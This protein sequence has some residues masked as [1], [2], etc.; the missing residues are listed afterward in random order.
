MKKCSVLILVLTMLLL[1]VACGGSSQ[2]TEPSST[3]QVTTNGTEGTTE[4]T[5]VATEALTEASTVAPTEAPTTPPAACNHSWK[6]AT[7]TE[8]K[9]CKTCGATNG[10]AVGHNWK[11]ATCTDP[12]KCKTCGKTEGNTLSHVEVIQPAAHATFSV[13]GLTEGVYC[14]L[15]GETLK[16]QT[17]I[18]ALGS[19]M[20]VGTDYYDKTG[21]TTYRYSYSFTLYDDDR[22]N[23]TT[24]KIGSD[25]SY[26]L[27]GEDGKINY[28]KNGVYE[29]IFDSS[30]EHMYG[31][32]V[33]G[34]FQFC[35]KDGKEWEDKETRPQGNTKV[36]IT[37]RAG[38][39]VYGYKDLSRN[40]HGEAMQ[41]LY[42]RL[43]AA[44][45]AFVD[46]EK[47][48]SSVK[49]EYIIDRINLEYY[50]LTA[51]EAVAVW[52]VFYIE[53]PRYY[54]L[55]NTVSLDDGVLNVCIDSAYAKGDVRKKCD[56]AISDLV[57][58]CAK[59]INAGDSQLQK[60]LTIHD[61][62]LG[63][64]NYAYKKDG[65][66][67][68]TAIWAHNLI[69]CA[70]KKSGV[71]ESYAKTYQYLCQLNGLECIVATGVNGENHAWNIVKI[72]EKWYG[73]DCTFDETNK[74]EVSYRCFG[75]NDSRMD[76]EYIE[77]T[78]EDSGI[79]YLYQL[80]KL[81]K[82]GVEL[83]EL[84]KND[85]YVGIYANVDAAFG[86]MTDAK[87]A[88]EV[89][90]VSYDKQGALL[91]SAAPVQHRIASTKTPE[92]KSIAIRGEHFDMGNGY[93]DSTMLLINKKLALNCDLIVY[94]LDIYG[95]GALD[96]KNKKMSCLGYSV[97][98]DIPI[99]G[100]L[101]ASSPSELYVGAEMSIQFWNEVQVY[102][103]SES[104][105]FSATLTFRNNTIISKC[106][107]HLIS[108]YDTFNDE[109]SVQ[110]G[111]FAPAADYAT[112]GIDGS[113]KVRVEKITVP[114]EYVSINF[115]FGKLEEFGAVTIGS[116]NTE[117]QLVLN[118]HKI[119]VS[120]DM[121]GNEVDRWTEIVDPKELNVPIATLTDKSVMEKLSVYIVD[122]S[123][124][125]NGCHVD[126]TAEYTLNSENQVVLKRS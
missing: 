104:A 80:P 20:V 94:D 27:T 1:L 15:C 96:L 53:N 105:D 25:E 109:I 86:A 103:L 69:G 85:N 39:S 57:E 107:A 92:V 68:E 24:L 42:Y 74:A 118:G 84:Y 58:A 10:K 45:E 99:T 65:I 50:V 72:D 34:Q 47:D 123:N 76:V 16:E 3:E 55:A 114:N 62:I 40:K 33:D 29:L 49:D 108:I 9:T 115:Q 125:G 6:D 71:C 30:K 21:S 66:T 54:W 106:K 102:M 46:S 56:K 26:E 32:I 59:K 93:Y 111:E 4:A 63:Q 2:T 75:M 122:W 77:D 100:N 5:Q 91:L 95:S 82:Q 35:N 18:P 38:N 43:F 124:E 90:L 23:L 52:K 70:Q 11:D 98:I 41:E 120:T 44:C 22:F 37:P 81:E 78:P 64:M 88:Y 8:P 119:T 97:Q 101:S 60:A 36:S 126:H 7:C 117:V 51:E 13:P 61:F 121:N 113:A 28:L 67:P 83:V 79:N 14:K 12:K 17:E 31:K 87:G 116:C 73:V 19:N 112:I 48:V 110:I 89:R